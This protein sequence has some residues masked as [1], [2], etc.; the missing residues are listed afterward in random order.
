MVRLIVPVDGR[1]G[2]GEADAERAAVEFA[3]ALLPAL[4]RH[5]PR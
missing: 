1:S 2:G 5:L 4:G 3:R